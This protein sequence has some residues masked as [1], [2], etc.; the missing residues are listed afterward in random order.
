M[1]SRNSFLLSFVVALSLA[2]GLPVEVSAYSSSGSS[3]S[4]SSSSKSSSSSSSSNRSMSSG[5]SSS[6]SSSSSSSSSSPKPSQAANSNSSS[7]RSMAGGFSSQKSAA[8]TSSS[9]D[10]KP[11]SSS[12]SKAMDQSQAQK[13][14]MANWDNRR[15]TQPPSTP[16]PT[17]NS[18]RPAERT[19]P[20]VA[21][22][23]RSNST[24]SQSA[25]D[26]SQSRQQRQE[27]ARNDNTLRDAAMAAILIDQMSSQRRT[28][29]AP[30][31]ST[32]GQSNPGAPIASSNPFPSD[33]SRT[34]TSSNTSSGSGASFFVVL[35][36]LAFFSLL[37]WIF[38][39]RMTASS[40][41]NS[42][43]KTTYR[44]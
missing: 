23:N 2:V 15:Q 44:L 26:Y 3:Q 9:Y 5:F 29:P 41:S 1:K 6:K 27:T 32:Y 28:A 24:Y 35:L 39:R 11:S 4:S 30:N 7:N 20:P 40:D 33:S 21:S 13:N 25:P 37:G 16:S 12:M 8:T 22:S 10:S 14:A 19:V 43:R 34:S 42:P 18:T 38:Y 31:P 17:A 36:T